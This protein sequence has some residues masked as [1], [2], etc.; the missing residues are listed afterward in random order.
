MAWVGIN[1]TVWL[2]VAFGAGW[3]YRLGRVDAHE[4]A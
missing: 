1:A 3:W 2:V 4:Q